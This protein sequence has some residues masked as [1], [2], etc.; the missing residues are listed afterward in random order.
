[1]YSLENL[2]IY[3]PAGKLLGELDAGNEIKLKGG[4]YFVSAKGK[5]YKVVI[6]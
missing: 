5:V 2:K 6:R 4:I 3:D 1:M